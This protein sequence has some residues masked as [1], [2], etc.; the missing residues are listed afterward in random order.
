MLQA[1]L[2]RG[3]F[4]TLSLFLTLTLTSATFTISCPGDGTYPSN[5]A[6]ICP[7]GNLS[8][9]ALGEGCLNSTGAG[10]TLRPHPMIGSGTSVALDDLNLMAVH[11]PGLGN[12]GL[13]LI[14]SGFPFPVAQAT[15]LGSSADFEGM[16]CV[17]GGLRALAGPGSPTGSREFLGIISAVNAQ[18]PG[19]FA[20]G[21]TYSMQYWHRDVINA[22][23]PCVDTIGPGANTNFSNTLTFVATP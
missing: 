13:L 5:N 11:P 6:L 19:F 14:D 8:G 12:G 22:G 4:V 23:T 9:V 7:C 16:L 3:A 20:P 2:V 15:W 17:G 18:V 21:M 1:K 10:T